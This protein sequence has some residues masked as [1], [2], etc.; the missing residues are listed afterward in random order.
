[1]SADPNCPK[2]TPLIQWGEYVKGASAND[3]IDSLPGLKLKGMLE[4]VG[5]IN[6]R[7]QPIKWPVGAWAKGEREKLLGHLMV[8]N[9]LLAYEPIA[10]GLFT[11]RLGWT[12]E[13]VEEFLPGVRNDIL[14]P[15]KQIYGQL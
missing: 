7:V 2:D 8:D 11:K 14:D 10:K 9:V 1:M 4:T 13:Q 6:I 5:F 15:K 12:M 3:G